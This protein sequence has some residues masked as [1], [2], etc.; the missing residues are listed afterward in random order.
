MDRKKEREEDR[1]REGKVEG[2]RGEKDK[3]F[4]NASRDFLAVQWLRL[5]FPSAGSMGPIP[6]WGTKIPNAT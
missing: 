1:Q 6:G 3:F 4:K 5:P 2:K